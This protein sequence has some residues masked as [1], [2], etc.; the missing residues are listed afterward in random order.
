VPATQEFLQ[1]IY[2]DAT[3][4][5]RHYDSQR[6]TFTQIFASVITVFL[7]AITAATT[8]NAVIETLP[9][10]SAVATALSF[11]SVLAILK[12]NSL[13]RLQRAR[14]TAA[15]TQYQS[16][17]DGWDF[18]A[19]NEEAKRRTTTNRMMSIQ[20]GHIWAGI[21]VVLFLGNVSVFVFWVL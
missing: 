8:Q 4:T 2:L 9:V 20:M 11:Y 19:I 3:Q 5:I 14:A 21:F 1:A 13:I 16:L 18:L 12:F 7:S 6:A 17:I 10:A 15:M